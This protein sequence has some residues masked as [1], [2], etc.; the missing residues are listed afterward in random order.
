MH[1]ESLA[2]K[3]A[4]DSTAEEINSNG[5]FD[6]IEIGT[7]KTPDNVLKFHVHIP[8]KYLRISAAAV[9]IDVGV[10]YYLG[11]K[12]SSVSEVISSGYEA[13]KEEATS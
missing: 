13:A 10:K 11:Y 12:G 6:G 1:N 7:E 9:V 4:I 8:T 5:S 3:K 2:D